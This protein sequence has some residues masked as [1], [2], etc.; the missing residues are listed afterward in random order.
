MTLALWG[1]G[2]I[3]QEHVH[4][5]IVFYNYIKRRSFQQNTHASHNLLNHNFKY[6]AL[7]HIPVFISRPIAIV[8]V[9]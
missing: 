9:I 1:G 6:I 3:C 4:L 2:A 7:A 8:I 5:F